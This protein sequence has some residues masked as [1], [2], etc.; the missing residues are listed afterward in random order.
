VAARQA[1]KP[2]NTRAANAQIFGSNMLMG[3]GHEMVLSSASSSRRG[4]DNGLTG[5]APTQLDVI[6]GLLRQK[7]C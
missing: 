5:G 6:N 3:M 1:A 4:C 7:D 2:W